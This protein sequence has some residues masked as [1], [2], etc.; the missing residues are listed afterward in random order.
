MAD[1]VLGPC[2]ASAQLYVKSVFERDHKETWAQS[3]D[4]RLT[5]IMC[6]RK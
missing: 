1:G 3:M 4:G 2:S 5:P 6:E